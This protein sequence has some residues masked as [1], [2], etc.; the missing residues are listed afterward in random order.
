MGARRWTVSA[1]LIVAVRAGAG[2]RPRLRHVTREEVERA[3]H[4]RVHFLKPSSGPTARGPMSMT[5]AHTGTTSLV[6]LAL[7]D[8]R[9]DAELAHDHRGARLPA[10]LRA[11]VA[12]RAPTPSRSRRWS[13]PRPTPTAT[14]RGSPPTSSGSRRPRSS[15]ATASTGPARGPTPAPRPQAATTRTP[16][17][18]CSGL[19]AASEVGVAGQARGLGPGPALLGAIPAHATAA[20]A[21]R[22]TPATDRRA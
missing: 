20:G 4:D 15:P 19:N 22:P 9:R 8:R 13:S 14:S 10:E 5:E 18:P 1:A 6:T 17:T 11:A 16:S 12:S 7:L 21:T 3:I 2:G